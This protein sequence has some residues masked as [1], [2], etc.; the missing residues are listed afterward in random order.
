MAKER[1]YARRLSTTKTDAIRFLMPPSI[2]F[3][4]D[5]FI[6]WADRESAHTLLDGASS[7][8]ATSSRMG[9]RHLLF[10]AKRALGLF[11]IIGIDIYIDDYKVMRMLLSLTR[12]R[13]DMIFL[14]GWF[15]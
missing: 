6:R 2:A 15:S 9:F 10:G 11:D 8:F 7:N 3:F 13:F 14:A 5:A 1:I 12:A 4:F